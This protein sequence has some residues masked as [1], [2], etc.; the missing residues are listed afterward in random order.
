MSKEEPENDGNHAAPPQRPPPVE[1]SSSFP[2]SSPSK[3]TREISKSFPQ[4]GIQRQ[5]SSTE[6]AEST[7]NNASIPKEQDTAESLQLENARLTLSR[8]KIKL[9][10]TFDFLFLSWSFQTNHALTYVK[11][12]LFFLLLFWETESSILKRKSHTSS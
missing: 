8:I 10:V 5:K 6:I 7:E 3:S 9:R 12:T 11:T 1:E 2:S 4:F